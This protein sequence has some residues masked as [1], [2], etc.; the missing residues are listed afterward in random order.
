MARVSILKAG[1]AALA[2]VLVALAAGLTY[3][4]YRR[5]LA[6]ERAR[7]ST[8]SRIA[9][10]ACGPIEFASVGEGPAVLIV[11]AA[12]GG[13]DQGLDFAEALAGAGLR[14]VTMSRFGYLR[15]PLPKEASPAAQA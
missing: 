8:G 2:A 11:H 15:T 9:Q 13:Y 10:T 12:G 4:S 6:L 7:V 1:V 5:E 14:V 3:E